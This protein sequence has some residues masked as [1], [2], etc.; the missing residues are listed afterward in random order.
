MSKV[1]SGFSSFKVD[2][3][4][5]NVSESSISVNKVDVSWT[6]YN[7]KFMWYVKNMLPFI[8]PVDSYIGL[9]F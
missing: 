1:C 7:T 6:F 5:D 8:P 4:N 3:S 2:E 9:N